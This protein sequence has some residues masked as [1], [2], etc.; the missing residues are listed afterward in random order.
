M[1]D[2]LLP[3]LSN[4]GA[5]P[6]L[7]LV[8]IIIS[9]GLL[10]VLFV[11]FAESGLLIGFF[12]P[13]DS[14]LFTVGAFYSIGLLPGSLPISIHIFVIMLFIAAVLGDTVG[15]WFGRKTG[16]KI[17][18]KPD[19]RLFK[20][21]HI[22]KAQD[23]YDKHGGKTIILARFI[24]IVRTFAPIV[25]GV[26]KME[27]KKFI[28]FNVIGGFLWTVGITY[29]GF[30]AGHAFQAAG[31]DVDSVLLPIIALIIFISIA[32]PAIHILKDK[33]NRQAL[34]SGIKR[35]FKSIFAPRKKK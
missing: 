16:H 30:F 20:Q 13:G 31:I 8:D 15:Y 19:A 25:A 17:F 28:S 1:I 3:V 12:L 6:G 9:G 22:Q 33:K 34:I 26:G 23:F 11:I 4:F 32:P 29:L 21:S 14:L 7:D 24:P 35:E 2:N 18:K 27:Y 5:I 10:A